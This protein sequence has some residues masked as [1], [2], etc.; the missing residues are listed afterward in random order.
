MM[1]NIK[2]IILPSMLLLA[3]VACAPAEGNKG[4][5]ELQAKRKG[6]QDSI[7]EIDAQLDAL[8]TI[9]KSYPKVTFY[10]TDWVSFEHYFAIQGS[11]ESDYNVV[12][13]PEAGGL[14]KSVRVVEGETI[15]K[16]EIIATF[17]AS[18]VASNI[19]ELREQLEV[20]EYNFG[21]Q[22]RLYD[23]GVG[24]EFNL[25]QAEGQFKSL[26]QTIKTLQTQAGKF[27]MTAPFSGYIEEVFVTQGETAGPGMPI[28][29]LI[30]TDNSYVTADVSEVY[31]NS[32]H[33]G[34]MAVV[35]FSALDTILKEQVVTQV[36]KFVNPTNR[37]LKIKVNLPEKGKFIPN[38]VATIKIRDYY[39]DSAIIVPSAT[40]SQDAVGNDIILVADQLKDNY[41]VR[42]IPVTVGKSYGGMTE[43]VKGLAPGLKVI[44]QGSRSVYEGLEVEEL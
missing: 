12:L 21:K 42:A 41:V 36:G 14:I 13:T 10:N 40:I 1:K 23:Q 32:L 26:S 37:T 3:I 18:I 15:K 19:K 7:K 17:D 31:L 30:N 33:K 4:V 22:Q 35:S 11:V 2:K 34:D 9:T 44:H 24:N 28:V 8:D 43:I 5:E 20:A 29:R 16:G 25:K 27:K 38:L 6:F 39:T